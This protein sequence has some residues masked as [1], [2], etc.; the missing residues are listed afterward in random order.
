MAYDVLEIEAEP[1]VQAM[2]ELEKQG[3]ESAVFGSLLHATVRDAGVAIP[4]I[5][6]D[7]GSAGIVVQRIKKIEPSLEDVF[8]TLIE[9]A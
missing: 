7:L 8:V 2:H 6:K 1:L 4:R 5:E 3:I 9:K